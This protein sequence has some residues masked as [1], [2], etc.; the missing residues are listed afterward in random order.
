MCI[1][2]CSYNCYHEGSSP[3]IPQSMHSRKP[4]S[5]GHII[6]RIRPVT[7]YLLGGGPRYV[8]KLINDP[9]RRDYNLTVVANFNCC[10]YDL[11]LRRLADLIGSNEFLFNKDDTINWDNFN[12]IK[13]QGVSI[14]NGEWFIIIDVTKI[15]DYSRTFFIDST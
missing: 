2:D 8:A 6:C 3:E 7:F 5:C 11:L 1:Y 4:G 10:C 15:P 13:T 12:K 9:H 14:F